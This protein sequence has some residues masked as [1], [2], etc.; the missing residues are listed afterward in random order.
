MEYGPPVETE[1]AMKEQKLPPKWP[2]NFLSWFCPDHLLEEIEGDLIQKFNRDLKKYSVGKSRRRFAWSAIRF[3]RPGIFLRNRFSSPLISF[4]MLFNY[5][6][7][8]GRVTARNKL[9]SLI[10]ISGLMLGL[11][12][13]L[14]MSLWIHNEFS[15]DDFHPDLD[16]IYKVYNRETIDGEINSWDYTPR[17]LAPTLKKDFTFIENSASYATY[18]DKYV[19]KAGDKKITND[20]GIYTD[21][22]FLQIFSFPFLSGNREKALN[23]P[24][25][26]II[27][28]SLAKALFDKEDPFGKVVSLSSFGYNFDFIITGVLAD[29]PP[30]TAFNFDFIIPFTFLESFNGAEENWYNNSVRTFVKLKPGAKLTAINE[31]IKDV[32]K[33]HTSSEDQPELFLYP[34]SKMHLYGH[35]ENGIES[36]GRI[37]IIRMLIIL[38]VSLVL[39]ACINFI[40]LSTARAQKRSKEIGI[41]KVTGANRSSLVIQFLFESIILVML[42]GISSL[43]LAYLFL[44]SFNH[45][46]QQQLYF[47]WDNIFFWLIILISLMAIGLL[48]GIYPA[49]YLSS[50]RP[51]KS[52]KGEPIFYSNRGMVRKALVIFQFGF[53]IILIFS[54]IVIKDQI[55]YLQNRQSG[56]NKENLIYHPITSTL[57][58]HFETYKN[59][60]ISSG[61]VKSVTRTSSPITER[62][63][64][65][66]HIDWKG[67]DSGYKVVIE[68]FFIDEDILATAGLKFVSGR[69]IDIYKFPSDSNAVILNET[70]VEVMEFKDP[71]GEIII[72]NEQEWQVVGVVEDFVLTSPHQKIPPVIMQRGNS[73]FGFNVVHLRLDEQNSPQEALTGI[74]EIFSKYD[75]DYPFEYQFVDDA[76]NTKFSSIQKTLAI[77]SIS[78]FIIIFIACIGLFALSLYLLEAKLKEIGVRKVFGGSVASIVNLLCW[79]SVKPILIAICLFSPAAWFAMRWWLQSYE[80]RISLNISYILFTAIFL[81]VLSILTIIVQTLKAA[82]TNPIKILRSE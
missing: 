8:A 37:E 44:P 80:Y 18:Q 9:F 56:Y 35:F 36:G 53:A 23:D 78:G 41:R 16:R 3:F 17:V 40:N 45:L 48:A 54:T 29:L 34:V 67:K 82:S 47:Q 20:N 32:P 31:Q 52:L 38:A 73:N 14:L 55:N 79:N 58:Q 76:Y 65:T 68:R 60:L 59:D 72:D 61:Y 6:K 21:A 33:I 30:N 5:F 49:A 69:E 71:I 25:S 2:F 39:I 10:N 15:F 27:T 74:S 75:P 4:I 81:L 62:F 26:I 70:A 28:E 64:S 11:T 57:D 22:D 63:S 66:Y 43:L 13:A 50:L 1:F 77:S 12:S 46:V 24:N 7:I 42:A 19:F 51:V